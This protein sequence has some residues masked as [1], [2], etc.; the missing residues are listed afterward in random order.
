MKI[1]VVLL[2][3][4]ICSERQI[5]LESTTGEMI[6]LNIHQMY[7][8][9]RWS[10]IGNSLTCK[11]H[12]TLTKHNDTILSETRP[13]VRQITEKYPTDTMPTT[14]KTEKNIQSLSKS[15]NM[16]LLPDDV[17]SMKVSESQVIIVSTC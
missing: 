10:L 15:K 13:K 14:E 8:M 17:Y 6:V 1:T 2:S 5:F 3:K 9:K 12:G 4:L 7:V 16:K 11:S